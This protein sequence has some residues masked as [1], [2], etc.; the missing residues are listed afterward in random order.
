MLRPPTKVTIVVTVLV[1]STACQVLSV[2]LSNPEPPAAPRMPMPPPSAF[3]KSKADPAK[4]IGSRGTVNRG[5]R[6]AYSLTANEPLN[7]DLPRC[8]QTALADVQ[9]ERITGSSEPTSDLILTMT[10]RAIPSALSRRSRVALAYSIEQPQADLLTLVML[11]QHRDH[12][13][14]RIH[15]ADVLFA[16]DGS[17]E[18]LCEELATSIEKKGIEPWLENG[19]KVGGLLKGY[20]V[21]Q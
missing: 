12:P 21:Q 9:F 8:I 16:A 13:L 17:I 20:G 11:G 1:L 4:A 19:G 7:S 10:A 6:I 14:R 18:R 3:V 15:H 2:A 5:L